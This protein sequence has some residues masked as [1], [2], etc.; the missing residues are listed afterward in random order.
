MFGT[1]GFARLGCVLG[2]VAALV[3]VAPRLTTIQ[4]DWTSLGLTLLAV[5][6]FGM[7]SSTFAVLGTLRVPL[8]PA[9]KAD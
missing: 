1:T 9:L 8:L 5:L 2:T 6:L 3:A 7:L 4:V